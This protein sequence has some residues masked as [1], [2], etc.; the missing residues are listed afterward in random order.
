MTIL[1]KHAPP[2]Q[3]S[4]SVNDPGIDEKCIVRPW[5]QFLADNDFIHGDEISFYFRPFDKVWEM[6]IRR[7]QDWEDTDSD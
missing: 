5:Y 7:Q 3:W 6:V 1:K 2:L 4:V